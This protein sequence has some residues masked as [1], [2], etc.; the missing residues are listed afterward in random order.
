M[1]AGSFLVDF[2]H[3]I[4]HKGLS[5]CVRFFVAKLFTAEKVTLDHLVQ[6]SFAMIFFQTKTD[7]RLNDKGQFLSLVLFVFIDYLYFF[8]KMFPVDIH[9]KSQIDKRSLN[10]RYRH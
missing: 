1:A 8:F 9:M 3:S 2:V 7:P 4:I 5:F 10:I 6:F